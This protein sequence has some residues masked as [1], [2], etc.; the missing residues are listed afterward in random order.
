LA[1]KIKTILPIPP[2]FSKIGLLVIDI[3]WL[4]TS[5]NFVL[6]FSLTF[7]SGKHFPALL[8]QPAVWAKSLHGKI[9]IDSK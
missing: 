2:P 8:L 6:K 7:M 3:Y 1:L 5:A 4:L 9:T